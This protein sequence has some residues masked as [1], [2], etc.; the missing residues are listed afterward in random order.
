VGGQEGGFWGGGYFGPE[1]QNLHMTVMIFVLYPP[2]PS[3]LSML[4]K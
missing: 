1:A 3:H 4:S 2:V